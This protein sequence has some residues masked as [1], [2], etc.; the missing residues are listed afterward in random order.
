M[1]LLRRRLDGFH[2]CRVHKVVGLLINSCI[3]PAPRPAAP[4]VTEMAVKS[5]GTNEIKLL[6]GSEGQMI[7]SVI[8]KT[9]GPLRISLAGLSE[10]S[11]SDVG[12]KMLY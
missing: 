12:L 7:F 10:S 8:N 3:E 4:P 5:M 9:L 11:Q 6:G 2:S 1:E